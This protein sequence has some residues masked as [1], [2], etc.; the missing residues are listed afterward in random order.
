MNTHCS[1]NRPSTVKIHVIVNP[2]LLFKQQTIYGGA[3]VIHLTIPSLHWLFIGRIYW[4]FLNIFLMPKNMYHL[5]IRPE[6]KNTFWPPPCT[7][8]DSLKQKFYGRI[9]NCFGKSSK[10]RWYFYLNFW[11]QPNQ[12]KNKETRARKIKNRIISDNPITVH[13]LASKG[14]FHRMQSTKYN[15]IPHVFAP[16]IQTINNLSGE[17]SI[18]QRFDFLGIDWWRW[19]IYSV[20]ISAVILLRAVAFIL[21]TSFYSGFCAVG[22]KV[23]SCFKLVHI[24]ICVDAFCSVGRR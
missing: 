5:A 20:H 9:S 16:I 10:T 22:E 8:L 3:H 13:P 6:I 24:M 4:N 19:G 14:T 17:I 15:I 23:C 2:Q 7:I 12:I 18:F 21:Q 1:R 11:F